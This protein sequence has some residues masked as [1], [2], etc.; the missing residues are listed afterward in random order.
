MDFWQLLWG[1]HHASLVGAHGEN[2]KSP[3]YRVVGN[4]KVVGLISCSNPG[5]HTISML[6]I[7]KSPNILVSMLSLREALHLT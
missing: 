1:E 5:L 2:F 6:P 3:L 4:L 7:S